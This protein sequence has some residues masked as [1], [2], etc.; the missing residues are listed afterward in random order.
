LQQS[1]EQGLTELAAVEDTASINAGEA[2]KVVSQTYIDPSPIEAARVLQESPAAKGQWEADLQEE[3]EKRI[4]DLEERQKR[5]EQQEELQR[6]KEQHL[7]DLQDQ[8]QRQQEE[9]TRRYTERQQQ[10]SAEELQ[11]IQIRKEKELAEAKQ[12]EEEAESHRDQLRSQ[13]A[14]QQ[15]QLAAEQQRFIETHQQLLHQQH[16][17]HQ[18]QLAAEQRRYSE[19]KSRHTRIEEE[20]NKLFKFA[21]DQAASSDFMQQELQ[22]YLVPPRHS[23]EWQRAEE[24]R[25]AGKTYGLIFKQP[26]MTAGEYEDAKALIT[27][28]QKGET[29]RE[30]VVIPSMEELYRAD[31]VRKAAK[32]YGLVFL[33]PT[34]DKEEYLQAWELIRAT[35][36]EA[37]AQ[38]ETVTICTSSS[39]DDSSSYDELP[40]QPKI[41]ATNA[42]REGIKSAKAV[43]KVVTSPSVAVT[44]VVPSP[45]VA[46]TKR[47]SGQQAGSAPGSPE[48]SKTKSTGKQQSSSEDSIIPA[49]RVKP[50]APIIKRCP[51]C[52]EKAS[53]LEGNVYPHMF[54]CQDS[55]SGMV[56]TT[57]EIALLKM[58]SET[59]RALRG[60]RKSDADEA[61]A[62]AAK[63]TR[64]LGTSDSETTYDSS[65]EEDKDEYESEDESS[66][67]T[68]S[69]SSSNQ[70]SSTSPAKTKLSKLAQLELRLAD[71]DAKFT[72]ILH[73][74][75][76]LKTQAPAQQ[77][78]A[79]TRAWAGQVTAA[80]PLTPGNSVRLQQQQ[81]VNFG[82]EAHDDGGSERDLTD[83]I[84]ITAMA[85]WPVM[86]RE[87]VGKAEHWESWK[88]KYQEY[89]SKSTD[90]DRTAATMAQSF[91]R[92]APWFATAFTC[93]EVQRQKDND[94]YQAREFKAVDIL[95]LTD[96]DFT[97][98][99]LDFC[100]VSI[101]DPSQV[102]DLL[103]KVHVDVSTATLQTVMHAC[104]SFSE[105]LKLVPK[106]TMA[107][108]TPSQ[109]RDAFLQS[110]FGSDEIR[111]RKVDYLKCRTWHDTTQVMIARASENSAGTAF[112]PFT[113]LKEFE[114]KRKSN[115]DREGEDERTKDKSTHDRKGKETDKGGGSVSKSDAPDMRL[116]AEIK[117]KKKFEEL[118]EK[119]GIDKPKHAFAPSWKLR[120]AYLLDCI[121]TQKGKCTRCKMRTGHSPSECPDP[122]SDVPYPRL[123]DEQLAQLLNL[124]LVRYQELE[125]GREWQRVGK[126]GRSHSTH[127]DPERRPDSSPHRPENR[128]KGRESSPYDERR[129]RHSHS[130]SEAGR[131]SR[132]IDDRRGAA[133]QDV[134]RSSGGYEQRRESGG[135]NDRR[136]QPA[137][138]ERRGGGAADDRPRV[139]EDRRGS[140]A[141]DPR[142][143]SS[144]PGVGGSG[145]QVICYRCNQE[146][147]KATECRETK[148]RDG[149][150]IVNR[151]SSPSTSRS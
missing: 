18:E 64:D 148:D 11:K 56:H 126:A 9:L 117:Y 26:C 30:D 53:K 120:Y 15:E 29:T 83:Q 68:S 32:P 82:E 149:K 124:R 99:Y 38:R 5:L 151:S 141:Q 7:Q 100:Q 87:H 118:A 111:N 55:K 67:L 72:Q 131:Y 47:Q 136:T 144:S 13:Q 66:T 121:D 101:K 24:I 76:G 77:P 78:Q 39:S 54:V 6:Q 75:G 4:A 62:E 41:P 80:T 42:V 142:A 58:I 14:K 115:K 79:T 2:G 134:R 119:E 130:P 31:E 92:W 129:G 71:Q 61:H 105:Q 17:Q 95:S 35:K 16:L 150:P 60:S 51:V 43:T 25:E 22:T 48:R 90:K 85:G 73:H 46:V 143:R 93:Q 8:M 20:H 104:D 63:G 116:P 127:R 10:E 96:A 74:L 94:R 57:E 52:G 140:S 84:L 137:Y 103:K 69:Q 50:E 36:A 34:M 114:D 125:E 147:H 23:P 98:R 138:E 135:Y 45:S 113:R 21:A 12:R 132:G 106:S 108:C 133:Q 123:D 3:Q 1:Q 102:L 19:L 65:D 49:R 89:F 86:P 28:R 145:Y 109:I 91:V 146:G 59:R 139:I 112:T 122:L 33:Q 40:K 37:G 88:S 97:K 27:A 128:Y 81:R 107:L 110:L 44:K 70:I